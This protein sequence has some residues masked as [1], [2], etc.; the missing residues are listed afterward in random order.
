MVKTTTTPTKSNSRKS[1][2]GTNKRHD[3]PM[4]KNDL[5]FA[6]DCEMVGIG[7]DGFDSAVARVTVINWE[8]KIVLDSFVKV[9]AQ[10]T[11]YRTHVSGIRPQDIEG[12]AAISFEQA[13]GAVERILRGKILIGH[14]L[15]NDLCA[16]GLTHPWCDV[17]DTARY[18]PYMKQVVGDDKLLLRPRKLRDLAWEKLGKQIQDDS[19]P[20]CPVEDAAAALDLYKEVRAH[21]EEGLRVE[22]ANNFQ[23]QLKTATSSPVPIPEYTSPQ[24]HVPYQHP[25][26]PRLFNG[27]YGSQIPGFSPAPPEY[28]VAAAAAPE[29][30]KPSSYTRRWFSSRAKSPERSA[31]KEDQEYQ[32]A[33]RPM[34]P[35]SMGLFSF[36]R[37]SAARR[38]VLQAALS[39]E[40]VE[41]TEAFETESNG[42]SPSKY[43]GSQTGTDDYSSLA[44][45][46]HNTEQQ[47]LQQLDYWQH[48][49]QHSIASSYEGQ[50]YNNN[51]TAALQPQ[52]ELSSATPL[53]SRLSTYLSTT[54]QEAIA[55][56]DEEEEEELQ[57][58][59]YYPQEWQDAYA[60][61]W[62]HNFQ[63]P[64]LKS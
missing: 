14:G 35:R 32:Q 39:A 27:P 47:Q 54:S 23:E 15:E 43:A 17:R 44:D 59:Q 3:A 58:E 19:K 62:S 8:H 45:W 1:N 52:K 56:G 51:N 9:P 41:T 28:P 48:G 18:A 22:Q 6:L 30:T 24:K 12:D 11:D 55:G 31:I 13:R 42:W 7:P 2:R 10:V 26:D 16:L 38:G 36:R 5:Y 33:P 64:N 20:H 40:T 50:H 61:E 25:V 46:S 57:Q 29:T 49:D 4:T 37:S 63:I 60:G 34:S 21:W 53:R